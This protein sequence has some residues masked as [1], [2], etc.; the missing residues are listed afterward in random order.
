MQIPPTETLRSIHPIF[1]V[2]LSITRL[3]L[4]TLFFISKLLL[5]PVSKI[6]GVLIC[7][8]YMSVNARGVL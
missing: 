4:L 2:K 3:E 6:G 5:D 7:F 8:E 1:Q